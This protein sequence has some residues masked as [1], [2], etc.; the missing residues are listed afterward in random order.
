LARKVVERDNW[1][2]KRTETP[3]TRD[4]KNKRPKLSPNF[5][6]GKRQLDTWTERGSEE[7]RFSGGNRQRGGRQK[8]L[9][10]KKGKKRFKR[11]KGL[12]G[13]SYK[14]SKKGGIRGDFCEEGKG[15]ENP[16]KIEGKS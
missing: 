14:G 2:T 15:P 13:G 4:K 16:R 7:E 12:K 10:G 6:R 5:P 9:T 3:G 11:K 8:D 1:G